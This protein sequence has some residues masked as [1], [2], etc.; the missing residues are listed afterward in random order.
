MEVIT[1]LENTLKGFN[2]K[3]DEVEGKIS[4]EEEKAMKHIQAEQQNE[5]IILKSE[6]TLGDLWD[7]IKWNNTNIIRV[8]KGEEKKGQKSYLKKKWQKIS[9]ILERKQIPKS[10]KPREFK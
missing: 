1:E 5:K 10:R 8:P 6:D 9:L 3:L 2:S 7:S 4:E